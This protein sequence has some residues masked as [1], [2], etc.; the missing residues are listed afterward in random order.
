MT[1]RTIASL[2][3]LL[4]MTLILAACNEFTTPDE[5]ANQPLASGDVIARPPGTW[6]EA[7]WGLSNWGDLVGGVSLD[8]H[9]T[10]DLLATVRAAARFIRA[11]S[12]H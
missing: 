2:L 12:T 10:V 7:V 11:Q 1:L 8:Q 6:G 5:K 4:A 9:R 3:S